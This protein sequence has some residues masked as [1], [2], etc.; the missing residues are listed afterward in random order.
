MR[1]EDWTQE[2]AKESDK[3]DRQENKDPETERT[4]KILSTC[5][6]VCGNDTFHGKS[7]GKTILVEV[8]PKNDPQNSIRL[9]AILDDQSNSCLA[10]SK[11]FDL[12]N[13]YTKE[14]PYSLSTCSGTTKTSGRRAANFQV[15]SLSDDCTLDLPTL[16]ECNDIPNF[17]EEIATPA[18]ARS[19]DHLT[20]IADCLPP[21]DDS[22]EILLLIERNMTEGF[23]VKD[24]R[25]GLKHS[26]YAQRLPLG[27]VVIGETCL[28]KQ[29]ITDAVNVNKTYTSYGRPTLLK[30]CVN[31]FMIK[32]LLERQSKNTDVFETTETDGRPGLSTEDRHFLE[33]L[34]E[35]MYQGENGTW[36]APLPMRN[37]RPHLPNNKLQAK[38]RAQALHKSLNK[39][40]NKKKQMAEFMTSILKAGHAEIAPPVENDK[41]V[42]YLPL[43]GVRHP[44]KPDQIRGVFDA[45]AAYEG[46]S[47][48]SILLQG[49]DLM[50]RLLHVL[51]SF[52]KEPV[53]IMG[54]IEKMFCCFQVHTSASEDFLRFF[55]HRDNNLSEDLIEYRMTV[56]VFGN[57]SS[58]AIATSGLRR[59]AGCAAEKFG[60]D[61]EDFVNKNFYVDD[62]L[63]SLPTD[64]EAINLLQRT[65]DALKT[66]GK[67][68]SNSVK[69]ME[70]FPSE[71]RN[72]DLQNIDFTDLGSAYPLQS[73]LGVS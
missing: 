65:Q 63:T 62:G 42:W 9:Y 41:E 17:R 45:S 34:D 4:S 48:N 30:P 8:H 10:K 71:D 14:I 70:A 16:I 15:R 56:H 31:N 6:E 3:P 20:D 2:K 35:D 53:A 58:P 12:M 55:W 18:V 22:A 29:H 50:N 72:K 68:A 61:V 44:R 5:T 43:F 25:V 49:P 69:V 37:P 57:K 36:T 19:H 40:E 54:D 73:S 21:L 51:L 38:Q 24:Q 60:S 27:W 47:L 39:D 32:P 13:I 52:R 23:H 46:I 1:R 66:Y 26:P 28:G 11:F 7:C 59:I 33:I 67:I 64:D